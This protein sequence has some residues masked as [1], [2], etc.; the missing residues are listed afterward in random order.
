MNIES[1][2]YFGSNNQ[3]K[4]DE[5]ALR[6]ILSGDFSKRPEF[7]TSGIRVANDVIA[8]GLHTWEAWQSFLKLRTDFVHLQDFDPK[9]HSGWYFARELQNGV[10]TLRI[11]RELFSKDAAN[12]TMMPDLLFKSGY[13]WKTL[14]PRN[15]SKIDVI[16]VIREALIN[17][18]TEESQLDSH[19]QVIIGYARTMDPFTAIRIRI[20]TEG[21]SIRSAFPTWGQPN[22]GNNGKPYSPEQSLS[23]TIAESTVGATGSTFRGSP[24]LLQGN[25]FNVFWLINITPDF[26]HNRPFPRYG[27]AADKWRHGWVQ[28]LERIAKTAPLTAIET[29]RKFLNEF[30]ISKQPFAVQALLYQIKDDHSLQLTEQANC[31]SVMQNVNDSFTFLLN[32]DNARGTRDFLDCATRFLATAVIHAG[33]LN[34]LEYK[35]LFKVFLEGALTHHAHDSSKIIWEALSAS[36]SRIAAYSEVNIYPYFKK[37]DELG[38]GVIG[39]FKLEVPITTGFVYDWVATNLGETYLTSFS[40]IQRLEIAE[41]Y[42]CQGAAVK[43]IEQSLRYFTASDFDFLVEEISMLAEIDS[44]KLPPSESAIIDLLREYDKMLLTYRQRVIL[45]DRD[46]YQTEIDYADH[47]EE[48]FRIL[49]QKHKRAYIMSMHTNLFSEVEKFANNWGYRRLILRVQRLRGKMGKERIPVPSR[50]PD[51]IKSWESNGGKI[52]RDIEGFLKDPLSRKI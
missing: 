2:L 50:I 29:T 1:P 4:L 51:Y 32:A 3:Y 20:Q 22:T 46:A 24:M 31:A 14:F 19:M 10:I 8:G 27:M 33:F 6:H 16:D 18:S 30:I 13:L 5:R 41:A 11:P 25:A 28:K 26:I 39:G 48:S 9:L 49:S 12:I 23:F 37:N 44:L 42:V 38:W 43:F 21:D 15:Y 34:M 45:E 7:D 47:S 40:K 17:I 35:R 36:P 52:S